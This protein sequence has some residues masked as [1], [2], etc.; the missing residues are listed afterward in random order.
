MKS[1][2][3]SYSL[4]IVMMIVAAFFIVF[5]PLNVNAVTVKPTKITL[6]ATST[7]I[8]INGKVKI[9]VKS[10]SPKNASKSVTYKTSNSKI[11][12]V[13]SKGIVKGKK[14]GTV[15]ITATS[16]KNKKVN[17]SKTIKVYKP[18]P[19]LNK[20]S[21]ALNTGNT[22]QLKIKNYT[23]PIK[24]KSSNT[25][26]AV[27]SSKGKI[28][29]KSTGE[30]TITASYKKG[31]KTIVL[32]C[33]VVVSNAAISKEENIRRQIL[34]L[35][36]TYK[37]GKTWTNDNYYYWSALHCH[38]YGCIALV[39]EMSDKIFG[40]DA[41]IIRHTDFNKIK[42][43]DHIRIGNYHSVMVISHT[44]NSI[45]VVEGNY[46]YSIHWFRQ[47]SKASLQSEGFYVET[48]Y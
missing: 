34:S 45:T 30:T 16:T 41:L 40:K 29:S 43:G 14:V 31:S 27:V 1:K 6:S 25:K 20:T 17:A 38:C 19:S 46:N 8:A 24:W 44:S 18:Q 15:K 26:V 35:Q 3:K 2:V 7:N 13:S 22:Y 5:N 47:I 48:R 39:G 42:S 21:L 11:A 32:K 23:G 36:N 33:N 10:V 12:S 28:I 37:E 9:T 4:L